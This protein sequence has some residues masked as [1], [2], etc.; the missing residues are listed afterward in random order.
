MTNVRRLDQFNFGLVI[1]SLAI[2][3]VVPFELLVIV[4]IFLGPAHYLTEISWLHERQYFTK[5]RWDYLYL[6]ALSVAVFFFFD[7]GHKYIFLIIAFFLAISMALTASW[8]R[9]IVATVLCCSLTL[10]AIVLETGT[11][12]FFVF[13][14][15]MIHII[16]F[17]SIFILVGA[18][19]NNS[20]YGF[21][22]L[23]AF[24]LGGITFF[25]PLHLG[26]DSTDYGLENVSLIKGM[27]EGLFDLFGTRMEDPFSRNLIGF[28]AFVNTYHYLNWFSKTRVIQWHNVPQSRLVIV[29]A[30][31]LASIGLYL[32]DISLGFKVLLLL[33]F[34]H[35]VLEFPLNTL[36]SVE[37][38][39]LIKR[40]FQ[41]AT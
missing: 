7:L 30:V 16:V 36:S 31:Y 28:V 6:V 19:R 2:A 24:L 26:I 38:G 27:Y 13:L 33:S 20:F 4:Y 25:F 23:S 1:A 3:H 14:P 21:G 12:W 34:F 15:N 22:T 17:T 18:L 8:P 29:A 39:R 32:Y 9:R 40:R 41:G 10:L 35:V 11:I 5:Y 37:A